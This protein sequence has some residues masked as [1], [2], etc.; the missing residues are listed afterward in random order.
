MKPLAQL[1]PSNHE[2]QLQL[3]AL[4]LAA[5]RPSAAIKVYSAIADSNEPPWEV[6]RNRADAYLSIGQHAEAIADYETA[7]K[8]QPEDDGVLNNL[9]WVLATSTIDGLR[10]GK[11]AIE[12]AM[13]ACELTEFK[14]AH[15]LSTLA[16]GYAETGDFEKAQE[17]SAKAVEFGEGP[18]KEQLEAELES[19]R[20]AKPWREMNVVEDATDLGTSDDDLELPP[21]DKVTT[22]EKPRRKSP[23]IPADP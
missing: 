10:D 13:K 20:Q 21:A 2:L 9:A 16:A 5:K 15:I 14:Q 19:Y 22:K 7:I 4:Y 17:W 1:D 23:R 6:F 11:R 18:V 3:A 12:L 8:K